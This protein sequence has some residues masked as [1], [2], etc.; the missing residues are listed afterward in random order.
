MREYLEVLQIVAIFAIVLLIYLLYRLFISIIRGKRLEDY[1]IASSE[2]N[3]NLEFKLWMLIHRFSKLL[4]TIPFIK[5]LGI[6]Y[7][8][9]IKDNEK[10]LKKGLDFIGI[11]IVVAVFMMFLY[12]FEI[13]L[14]KIS[15]NLVLFLGVIVL[16]FFV[17]NIVI[18]LNYRKRKQF[19]DNDIVAAVIIM[20][21]CFRVGLNGT[22]AINSVIEKLDGP[23][24]DEFLKIKDDM[25]H[26]IDMG[27]SFYRMYERVNINSILYISNVLSLVSKSGISM[28][29]AFERI[30]KRIVLEKKS[31]ADV[32]ILKTTNYVFKNILYFIPLLFLLLL[33]FINKDYLNLIF[34]S[35]Y[36][37]GVVTIEVLVY[38]LYVT[39]INKWIRR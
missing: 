9:Y 6:K 39:A 13:L 22:Q 12:L 27:A 30:E 32:I 3:F 20:N 25:D 23:I 7:D 11:K 17:P 24:V 36:G 18:F 16:G 15:F 28:V 29:K 35:K 1:A 31:Q 8:K 34:V 4:G 21:N 10:S 33:I 2:D 5:K 26:G 38:I 37:I 19:I 14:H